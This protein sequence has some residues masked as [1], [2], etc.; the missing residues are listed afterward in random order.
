MLEFVFL[1]LFVLP[2]VVT[3]NENRTKTDLPML[4]DNERVNRT[5]R[6]HEADTMSLWDQVV[7]MEH[8]VLSVEYNGRRLNVWK[9]NKLD[10]N[11]YCSF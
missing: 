4:M 2:S 9:E 5:K 8:V 3:V 1:S 10:H 11:R 6:Q 7:K